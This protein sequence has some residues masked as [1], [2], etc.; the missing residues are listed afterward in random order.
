MKNLALLYSTFYRLLRMN[1]ITN[2]ILKSIIETFENDCKFR[3]LIKPINSDIFNGSKE[4]IIKYGSKKSIRTL[5]AIQLSVSL[6][7]KDI[8]FVSGDKLLLECAEDEDLRVLK[9]S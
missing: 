1:E 7:M 9:V 5:D 6:K 2:V 3:F 8:V 4:L